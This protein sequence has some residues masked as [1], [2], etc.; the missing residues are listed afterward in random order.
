M[1]I[2]NLFVIASIVWIIYKVS[3]EDKTKFQK[4]HTI[5]LNMFIKPQDHIRIEPALALT[6]GNLDL[7]FHCTC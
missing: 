7:V 6:M 3:E 5:G 1:V 2:I 4:A